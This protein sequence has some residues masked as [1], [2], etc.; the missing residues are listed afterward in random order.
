MR[1]DDTSGDEV[2]DGKKVQDAKGVQDTKLEQAEE[3]LH[4]L[5]PEERLREDGGAVEGEA[6]EDTPNAADS[7]ADVQH[8]PEPLRADPTPEAGFEQPERKAY[9]LSD[10]ELDAAG[11]G[12]A[13][14]EG[15][16]PETD[17]DI[18]ADIA[19]DADMDTAIDTAI[20]KE[21]SA[22]IAGAG[23][24]ELQ[25]RRRG[26]GA[27]DAY[28]EEAFY[29][30]KA[31]TAPLENGSLHTWGALSFVVEAPSLR[32]WYRA[33]AVPPPQGEGEPLLVRPE[34]QGAVWAS[35]PSHRLL[36]PVRYSGP[37][38]MITAWLEG[39]PLR[40]PLPPEDVLQYGLAL[41]QLLRFFGGHRQT[42]LHVE[43][44]SLLL[45]QAGLRLRLP[46]QLAPLG[47][48]LPSFYREGY[49]PPEVQSGAP[50]SG[51]E[52]VYVLAALLLELL[53]GDPPPPEGFGLLSLTAVKVPGMPQLLA[54]AS[55]PLEERLDP[56][57][58]FGALQALHRS[59]VRRPPTFEIAGAT[60]VG[61]NPNRPVNEDSYGY[62]QE[63]SESEGHRFHLL[64]ACVS[65][66]MGGEVAGEVA[67]RAAVETFLGQSPS[68]P[69]DSARA[70]TEWAT[71]L[72]WEANR[73]AVE[74]LAGRE[75]GCTFT[76][77]VVL[78]E[79]LSLAHVGDTR[80]YLYEPAAAG[81]QDSGGGGFTQLTR[82]HSL[83]SALVANGVLSEEEARNSPDR[84]K[85]LRSL[86]SL[87]QPQT[88]YVD[89][90]SAVLADAPHAAVPLK[91][92]D[93]LLLL[94]DGV[95]G[96]LEDEALRATVTALA[97]DPRGLVDALIAAVLEVGASDNATAL[98]IRRE[99]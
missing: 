1:S 76:G 19:V 79:R 84:N 42:V 94:S 37:E 57:A 15:V 26:D 11:S 58:F 99:A 77:V 60:T 4:D 38:G 33:H 3:G 6:A 35:L 16:D 22:E 61:L 44:E 59:V 41:A 43:P 65:D 5:V 10:A 12:V 90:L 72:V 69:L 28:L 21:I 64:R 24:D 68:R 80:A 34:A 70:Q 87:R 81:P 31:A 74:A 46:P 88:G 13:E 82:D 45:T 14:V 66:G 98:A 40:G 89:D 8:L 53:T 50:A 96:D 2:Q 47:E 7:A 75:G 36:P 78:G 23:A 32:G 62:L 63:V 25:E 95:W 30:A 51:K 71:Q 27:G 93:L 20:D 86:G 52:G 17:I 83:V 49:T 55:A 29:P 92:G 97:D 9:E 91:L 67:S 85:V 54:A 73:A 39:E 56:A 48:P 18:N